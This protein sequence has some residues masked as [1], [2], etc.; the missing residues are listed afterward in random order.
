MVKETAAKFSAVFN[1]HIAG[2]IGLN[3]KAQFREMLGDMEALLDFARYGHATKF[4]RTLNTTDQEGKALVT[5]FL[6]NAPFLER[7][8]DNLNK[9]HVSDWLTLIDQKQRAE[10]FCAPRVLPVLLEHDRHINNLDGVANYGVYCM[11][12]TQ[13]V[14][15][16]MDM[17]LPTRHKIVNAARKTSGYS[18]EK[19]EKYIAFL[20]PDI[21]F[22]WQPEKNKAA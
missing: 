14:H 13:I 16:L 19:L 2:K 12:R 8:I 4:L 22:F 17:N 6:S 20:Y 9:M 15:W 5:Q 10:V 18:G 11:T 1:A 21:N 3:A 7:M